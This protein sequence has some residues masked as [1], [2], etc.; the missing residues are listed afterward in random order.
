[1]K[2]STAE[3][4]ASNKT[5]GA[6]SEKAAARVN[7]SADSSAKA[8]KRAGEASL[9]AF[10]LVGY[11]SVKLALDYQKSVASIAANADIPV[12]AAQKIGAAFLDTAGKSVFSGAQMAAAFAP[13]A[14]QLKLTEGGAL[15]AADSLRVMAVATDLA[16]AAQLPLGTTTKAV[17]AVMQSFH[18]STRQAAGAGDLLFNVSRA[19]NLPL[20][21]VAASI[22]KLH[23]RM[24]VLMPSMSDIG[25]LMISLAEHG[26]Q[27]SRGIQVVQSAL[28]TLT[29]GG[30]ASTAMLKELGVNVFDSRGKFVGMAAVIDQLRPKLVGLTQQSQELALKALFGSGAWQVLGQV[31]GSGVPA[32]DAATVSAAKLGTAHSAATL[33]AQTLGG[34]IKILVA[35][36]SDLGVK[37][38]LVLLPILSSVGRALSGTIVWMQKH[39]TVAEALAFAIGTV[40]GTAVLVFAEQKAVKFGQGIAS[41]VSDIGKL[42]GK[43][44]GL[45]PR[46][47]SI[48]NTAE[49]SAGKVDAASADMAA[50]TA[51]ASARVGTSTGA[52]DASF[53]GTGVA[54]ARGA[55]VVDTA[56]VGEAAT[57]AAEDSAIEATN[58]AAGLSFTAMLGPIGLVAAAVYA[59][60]GPLSSVGQQLGQT[61]GGSSV[62]GV[63]TSM[64]KAQFIA[65]AKA[66]GVPGSVI[67]QAVKQHGAFAT[68]AQAAAANKAA[69]AGHVNTGAVTSGVGRGMGAVSNAVLSTQQGFSTALLS[70]YGIK[71]TPQRLSALYAWE[72]AEKNF[73]TGPDTNNPLNVTVAP[74]VSTNKDGVKAIPSGMQGLAATISMLNRTGIV[75]SGALASGNASALSQAVTGSHWGTGAFGGAPSASSNLMT[76]GGGSSLPSGTGTLPT[77]APHVSAAASKAAAAATKAANAVIAAHKHALAVL[78]SDN[79]KGQST[80]NTLLTLGQSKSLGTL[81]TG[82]N[83]V[84]TKAM[85]ALLKVLDATHNSVLVK[86][87]S[88]IVAAHK[89]ALSAQG[90][91]VTA[92]L[93]T[94]ITK[95][96]AA[97]SAALSKQATAANKAALAGIATGPDATQ[98]AAMQAQDAADVVAQTNATNQAALAAATASGDQTA[99]D[100]ANLAITQFARQQKEQQLT[101]S[102]AAATKGANDALALAQASNA[103]QTADYVAQLQN[104]F[105]ALT[106][107]LAARKLSWAKYEQDVNAL[108]GAGADPALAAGPGGQGPVSVPGAAAGVARDPWQIN[109]T[110]GPVA[111][112]QSATALANQI[113]FR[114][115][116]AG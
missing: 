103:Q 112:V 111:S 94:V 42:S 16:E 110:T 63:P 39:K 64:T 83:S 32:F 69:A 84:H 17:A 90:A 75:S 92:T 49:A 21:T 14:G 27:G 73:G 76:G 108:L 41:M 15:G 59:L 2:L 78:A 70:H 62:S 105:N 37:L 28:T 71:A 82:L 26:I 50:K 33:Q 23:G 8:W 45:I 107:H 22:D 3:I 66:K 72:N 29:G 114:I 60:Q 47:A 77:A 115:R 87:A 30:K 80:L 116:Y 36:F 35:T 1:M 57:V 54:A 106:A 96:G 97:F 38:G 93:A 51:T 4:D 10:A 12:K 89:T 5:V 19:L 40:L 68:A 58:V 56:V 20:D 44:I 9:A 11:G 48:G 113:A 6:S 102:I 18:L 109:V 86:L 53:T 85:N 25:G 81:N 67:A 99:I 34:Q 7:A 13:V 104:Q 98:L 91:A 31:V 65:A 55:A 74:G 46:I 24:G 61:F 43:I 52:I 101:D 79:T 100:A 95:A 88:Q